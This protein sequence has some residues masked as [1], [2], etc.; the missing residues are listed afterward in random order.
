MNKA[1][2]ICKYHKFKP[3]QDKYLD[4]GFHWCEKFNTSIDGA[5]YC[6]ERNNN[7]RHRNGAVNNSE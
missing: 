3:R 2:K 1:C 4:I 5:E 6:E 7:K